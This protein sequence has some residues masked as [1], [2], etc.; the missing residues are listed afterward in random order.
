MKTRKNKLK[1]NVTCNRCLHF[2]DLV[3]YDIKFYVHIVGKKVSKWIYKLENTIWTVNAGFEN[4]LQDVRVQIWRIKLRFPWQLFFQHRVI[5]RHI[6]ESCVALCF[7]TA[8]VSV[9]LGVPLRRSLQLCGDDTVWEHPLV[10]RMS[11]ALYHP[12]NPI[13]QIALGPC[14]MQ[15]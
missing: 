3:C 11:E 8:R 5:L 4:V 12:T 13:G 9:F 14:L 15:A 6:R 7:E 1:Y 10:W 2:Q